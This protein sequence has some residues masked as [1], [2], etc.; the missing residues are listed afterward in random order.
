MNEPAQARHRVALAGQVLDAITKRAVA[1]AVLSMTKM[2]P[3]FQ[4]WLGFHAG[5]FGAAWNGMAERPDRTLSRHDGLFYFL[6]LPEGKYELNISAPGSLQRYG[7]V[8]QEAIVVLGKNKAYQLE[9]GTVSLPPTAIEGCITSKK[10]AISFAQVRVQGSGE[11]AFSD[12]AGQYTITG[13]EPGKRTLLA[14]AQG[15]KP[16]TKPVTI[17]NPGDVQTVDFNLT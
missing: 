10:K 3:A 13:V 16:A 9:W 15:Y 7:T 14:Y 2:P 11:S 8:T 17:A 4:T 6:D 1:G 12:D 5:Q